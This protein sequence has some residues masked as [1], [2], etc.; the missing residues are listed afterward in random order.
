MKKRIITWNKCFTARHQW[1]YFLLSLVILSCIGILFTHENLLN[2]VIM[3]DKQMTLMLN[4]KGS[5]TTDQFWYLYSKLP[6]WIPLIAVI[7]FNC[8]RYHPGTTREKLY[9]FLCTIVLITLLDQTSASL[10]KPFA[11]RL[12]PSHTPSL[13]HLLH[14][15]NNYRGGNYGFVS[16]HATNLV[17]LV[18]W[19][20]H[21]FRHRV[22]RITMFCFAAMMCYSRIYLGVHFLG[23]V[24]MGSLLGFCMA[25]IFYFIISKK[26]RFF[27]T[28][29]PSYEI[30]IVYVVTMLVL[31]II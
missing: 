29:H 6:T 26:L 8:L 11:A 16:S 10:I 17:G 22:I 21:F 13:C 23:D 19:L 18:T 5:S 24:L 12:R 3:Q 31:L 30:P 28:D 15:V 14:Y 25:Q 1:W 4:F 7:A 9:F 2:W 27:T 20:W